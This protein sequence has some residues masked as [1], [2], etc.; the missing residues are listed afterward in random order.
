MGERSMVITVM[1]LKFLQAV[2]TFLITLPLS[3]FRIHPSFHLCRRRNWSGK[4]RQP[5]RI[6]AEN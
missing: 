3:R 1:S 5:T 6:P 4:K 2:L